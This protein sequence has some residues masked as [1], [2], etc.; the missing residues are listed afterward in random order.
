MKKAIITGASSGLGKEIG[1]I[2]TD[3]G[4]NVINLSRK[5]SDYEDIP[6]DLSNDKDILKAVEIIN[7]EHRDIDLLILNSGIMPQANIGEVNF[8]V[9]DTF[10]VNVTG[11]I[12]IVNGLLNLIKSNHGDIV[13]VGSTAAFNFFKGDTVYSSAKH[14]ILG[15]T[16]ALQAE[17]KK[18]NVRIIGFHPGAFNSNLRNGAVDDRFMDSKDLAELMYSIV[19]LPRKMQVSEI[20]IDCKKPF[21]S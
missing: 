12:K 9:D 11:S 7:K 20:I 10:K 6:V 14:A 16:K 2:L 18:E 13:I 17:L 1:K 8:N 4:I 5:P 21:K 19:K 3:N 15:F